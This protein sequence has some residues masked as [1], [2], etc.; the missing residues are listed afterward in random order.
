MC[1][2]FIVI[3]LQVKLQ[4][5]APAKPGVYHYTVMLRSDSYYADFDQQHNIKVIFIFSASSSCVRLLLFTSFCL[6]LLLYLT[7]MCLANHFEPC[8]ISAA[9][10]YSQQHAD[11]VV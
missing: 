9:V 8:P 10:W 2:C 5:S 7:S 1:A 11:S 4:F 6:C 3:S